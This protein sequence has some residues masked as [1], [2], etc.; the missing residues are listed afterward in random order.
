MSIWKTRP[1]LERLNNFD[2]DTLGETLGMQFVAV[3]ED[4]LSASMPVDQRTR[5]PFGI[6]HGGASAALAEQVGSTAG[7]FCIDMRRQLPVGLTLYCNHLGAVREG[8]VTA[9]ASAVH[10]GGSTQVWSIDIENDDQQRVCSARLTL[11][12]VDRDRFR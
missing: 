3:H 5:Q 12:I 4:G 7:S 2:K 1:S 6:L 10:L 11:A 8:M 9:R